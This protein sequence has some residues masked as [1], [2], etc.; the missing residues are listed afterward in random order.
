[1]SSD[2]SR[3]VAAF[4]GLV[5]VGL[6]VSGAMT[7]RTARLDREEVPLPPPGAVVVAEL[8]TSEGC[9]S[10]PAADQIL[11]QLVHHRTI[12]GVEVLGL[13]EHVD[14]WNRLG[15][16]DPFSSAAFST[17]QEQYNARV[18]HSGIYTPQLVVDGRWQQI[19]S[20]LSAVRRSIAR[21]AREVKTS[22]TLAAARPTGAGE[23]RVD[24]SVDV[25]AQVTVD[26]LADVV[27]AITEDHLVSDV[28]RGENRG[29]TLR[30][31]A[32]VRR[33]TAIGALTPPMRALSTTASVAVPPTWKLHDLRLVVFLQERR[34]RRIIGAA[35]A[36]LD[37]QAG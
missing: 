28:R 11:D 2:S 30:H 36:S 24:I 13:G 34:S 18:F 16:S 3:Q 25:P 19:G 23:W 33:L 9:S 29:R 5:V 21:A 27:V 15:W 14:Y 7:L 31:S 4:A 35:A 37:G 8:F 12:A 26:E 17:R 20:D 32:V 1:M 22:V 10:C 6:L